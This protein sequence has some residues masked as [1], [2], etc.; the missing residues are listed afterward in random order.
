MKSLLFLL[1]IALF[2][3]SFETVTSCPEGERKLC[4]TKYDYFRK[5]TY[6]ACECKKYS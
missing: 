2:G 4:I 6:A 5:T 1:L 3:T